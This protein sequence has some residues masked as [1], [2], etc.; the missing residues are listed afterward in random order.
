MSSLRRVV[1]CESTLREG[2]LDWLLS[3]YQLL[4]DNTD[5]RSL[6]LR[7]TGLIKFFVGRIN[8]FDQF[9]ITYVDRYTRVVTCFVFEEILASSLGSEAFF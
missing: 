4:K 7:K 2:F 1:K 3:D 5:S 9:F 6:F 8:N